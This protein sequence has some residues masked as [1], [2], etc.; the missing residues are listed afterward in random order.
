MPGAHFAYQSINININ[1]TNQLTML[2]TQLETGADE[3]D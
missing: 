3:L 2:E 1:L